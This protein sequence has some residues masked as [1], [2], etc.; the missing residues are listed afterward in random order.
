MFRAA[1]A[2]G[3]EPFTPGYIAIDG[4]G[5]LRRRAAPE[6]RHHVPTGDRSLTSFAYK[7]YTIVPR[8]FQIRGSGRWTLE[9][10][11]SRHRCTRWFSGHA[12][13]PTEAVAIAGCREYG[14]RIIDGK[15]PDCTVAD[16]L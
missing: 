15:V 5:P 4:A 7:T 6:R 16:L 13:Y 3:P 11:I 2:D 14:C 1:A 9:V 10:V 8:T 12:T